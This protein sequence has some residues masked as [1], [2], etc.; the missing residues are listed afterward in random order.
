MG[1]D[2]RLK[3]RFSVVAYDCAG[4]GDD[5][6]KDFTNGEA[7]LAYAKALEARFT[8]CVVKHITID[9]ISQVIWTH[10]DDAKNG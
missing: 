9:P 2:I 7:A 1:T 10:G 5:R 8:P 6:S 3:V 4:Y